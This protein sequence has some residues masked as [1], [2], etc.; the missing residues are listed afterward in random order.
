MDEPLSNLDAKLRVGMRAELTRLH[1]RLGVTTVYVTHDQVEAMT[2]GQRVAVM[3]AG[4]CSRWP[5]PRVLYRHP[6]NL[7][8]AAFIGS[9]S[10]NL[11]DAVVD[12]GRLVRGRADFARQR[13]RRRSGPGRAR[14]PPGGIR[15]RQF[16]PPGL[17]QL[18]VEVAVVEELGA[19]SH[20]IFPIEAKPVDTEE[21][22]AAADDAEGAKLLA[23]DQRALFT[24]RVNPRTSA[25]ARQRIRLSVDPA[26]LYFFD[27]E[28][29]LSLTMS[30]A[31]APVPA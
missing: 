31:K 30:G 28:T 26:Q 14:H 3:R 2:L 25:S 19:E 13:H 18:E 10:M 9:P 20:V 5:S 24:A 7:F 17:P 21:V 12:N 8:V 1:E 23:D 4:R 29:R 15:G 11:V 27:P 16:A 22:K 6:A